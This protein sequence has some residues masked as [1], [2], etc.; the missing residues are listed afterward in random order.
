MGAFQRLAHQRG[1]AHALEGVIRAT[2]GE[3]DE[4]GN[5]IPLHLLR[6]DEVGHAELLGH[7][8]APGID[9]HADDLLGANHPQPLDHVQPNAA[10]AEHHGAAAG[11]GLGCVHHRAE[12]GGDAA[13][14]VADFV[15]RRVL[16]DFRQRDLRQHG[17]VREC[18]G[19]HVMGDRLAVAREPAGAV[20]HQALA[21]G[22]ADGDAEIGLA[23]EAVFAL[24]A[25]RRVERN[26][27]IALLQR[28]HTLADIHH[29]AR[30]LMAE[31]GGENA[32]R[33]AAREGEF[34]GM[35]NTGGLYLHQHLA[36]ARAGEVNGFQAQGR[37][38]LTGHGSTGFH[39]QALLR[40][41]CPMVA[42][43]RRRVN[44]GGA[45]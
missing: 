38:G 10:E 39:G 37:A 43:A 12:A 40:D 21:L 17:E 30:T 45:R 4:V 7:R 9:V 32:F 2:P 33:V 19:A 29:H 14:D 1:V 8:L 3:V 16:A 24:P 28:G 42:I 18:G 31:D 13:A 11:L 5:Q 6:V 27:V 15:K 25:F 26:D 35:A 23:A 44:P 36:L 34:V 22:G 41:R 20:R